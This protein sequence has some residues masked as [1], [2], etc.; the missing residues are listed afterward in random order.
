MMWVDLL[1]RP[2]SSELMKVSDRHICTL[3]LSIS[4][5]GCSLGHKARLSHEGAQQGMR[6]NQA[7]VR[8][9]PAVNTGALDSGLSLVLLGIRSL[10]EAAVRQG[11][12]RALYLSLGALASVAQ[13]LGCDTHHRELAGLQS[14]M[15]GG[16]GAVQGMAREKV[17][18]ARFRGNA[19][20]L[21]RQGI[22]V[23]YRSCGS[24]VDDR[25]LPIQPA[26]TNAS[27]PAC[28]ASV[29]PQ[30]PGQSDGPVDWVSLDLRIE[31]VGR[32]WTSHSSDMKDATRHSLA[33][34]WTTRS[35]PGIAVNL[36][37][38][39]KKYRRS[40]RL[41]YWLDSGSPEATSVPPDDDVV[42][43]RELMQQKSF[44][45]TVPLWFGIEATEFQ[46]PLAASPEIFQSILAQQGKEF[47]EMQCS[48]RET[49]KRASFS[50]VS[51]PWE[52][53]SIDQYG[54]H[55]GARLYSKTF[56]KGVAKIP[57]PS[58]TLVWKG[59]YFVILM[60]EKNSAPV[61]VGTRPPQSLASRRN[62]PSPNKPNANNQ[63][64]FR[65]VFIPHEIEREEFH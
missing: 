63:R 65:E 49:T 29:R 28:K 27:S 42:L 58:G 37:I 53:V 31:S 20:D 32:T 41:I 10:R 45:E 40:Y 21:E 3:F 33:R 39:S 13:R 18:F 7:S 47:K 57:T 48:T 62:R 2:E 25:W 46:P 56:L 11:D 50:S 34:A 17:N 9:E 8:P 55:T 19:G 38:Y 16:S 60:D 64:L 24:G 61:F 26:Q 36:P 5:S 35:R 4:L 52:R 43:V 15:Y 12:G 14:W 23:F 6:A 44:N 54:V 22:G 1:K 59:P 30:T 51:P